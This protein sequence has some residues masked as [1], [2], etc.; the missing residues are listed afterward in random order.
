MSVSREEEI[1]NY[2]DVYKV[3]REGAMFMQK[4]FDRELRETPENVKKLAEIL[5]TSER[6]AGLRFKLQLGII[7]SIY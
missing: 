7:D 3:T 2:M 4:F 6:N 1:V 5:G